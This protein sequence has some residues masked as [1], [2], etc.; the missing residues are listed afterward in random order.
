MVVDGDEFARW[1]SEA[2]RALQSAQV[3]SA[4]GLHN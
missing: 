3:Q 4:A 1:R 2:D